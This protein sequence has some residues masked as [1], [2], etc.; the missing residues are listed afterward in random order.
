MCL[1]KNADVRKNRGI[2]PTFFNRLILQSISNILQ[3]YISIFSIGGGGGGRK[4]C[5]HPLD[6]LHEEKLG[7]DR[8][9]YVLG[10]FRSFPFLN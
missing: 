7:P 6:T 5:P 2:L 3:S 8:V 9:I 10:V 1:H 4:G